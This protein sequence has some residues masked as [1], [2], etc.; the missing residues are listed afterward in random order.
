MH[1][2]EV[3]HVHW[4]QKMDNFFMT[5]SDVVLHDTQEMKDKE[6]L[7]HPASFIV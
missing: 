5:L 7:T 3:K 2:T 1:T 6:E 4:P